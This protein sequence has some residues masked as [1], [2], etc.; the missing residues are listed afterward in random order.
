MAYQAELM[1]ALA[2]D[3]AEDRDVAVEPGQLWLWRRL[4]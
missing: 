4:S 2:E 3:R 1:L